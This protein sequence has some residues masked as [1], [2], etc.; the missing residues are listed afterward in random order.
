MT[1]DQPLNEQCNNCYFCTSYMKSEKIYKG[2]FTESFTTIITEIFLCKRYPPS[3]NYV[4]KL[5]D[6]SNIKYRIES[7]ESVSITV[8][9]PKSWCGE[10][11]PRK[12]T[13]IKI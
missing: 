13:N 1:L 7:S 10:W 12:E 8:T 5:S 3:H 9:N 11:K 4:C 6:A 2:F